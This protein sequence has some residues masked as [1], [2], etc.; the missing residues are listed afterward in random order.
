MSMSTVPDNHTQAENKQTE[1]T[2]RSRRHRSPMVDTQRFLLHV[3]IV[4]TLVWLMFGVFVGVTT[5]PNGDMYPRVDLGDLVL[6]YKTGQVSRVFS[7]LNSL[8]GIDSEHL[9]K[10]QDVVVLHKND[11]LYLGRIVAAG[12]DTVEISDS[13]KLVVNGSQM[14]ESNIFYSTPR[15]E[16]FVEYPVTLAQDEVFILVDNRVGGEDSRYYGPVKL[17]EIDGVVITIIRRTNL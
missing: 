3:I 4:I 12:G 8:L 7:P 1:N 2:Q 5:A 15:Y 16:G 9:Y 13:D 11:T 10:A 6:Y 14:V 17:S